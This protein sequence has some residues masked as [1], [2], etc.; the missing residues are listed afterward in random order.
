[1][2][3]NDES[4]V[5][6]GK[7]FDHSVKNMPQLDRSLV[8]V[9]TSGSMQQAVSGRSKVCRADVAAAL[10]A[11]SAFAGSDVGIFGHTHAQIE[12]AKYVSPLRLAEQ[13]SASIGK[14]GHSTMGY[15]AMRAMYDKSKHDRVIV[16]TDDQMAD[17]YT[18]AEHIPTI[19]FC[20]LAGYEPASSERGGNGRY[21]LGGFSDSL[22]KLIEVLDAGRN[23]T[24]PF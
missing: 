22:Y 19:Y 23:A 18:L 17:S 21:T 6:L 1:M 15:T 24:W 5:A 3:P 10:A 13:I 12:K 20:D 2:S 4:R 11:A 14:V 8:L 7:A 16:F 9:D